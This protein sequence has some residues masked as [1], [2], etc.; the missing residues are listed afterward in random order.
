MSNP[1]EIQG[2]EAADCLECEGLSSLVLMFACEFIQNKFLG[3]TEDNMEP[4]ASA[5]I[6]ELQPSAAI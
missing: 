4:H 5:E 3:Q 2:C 6:C 1:H